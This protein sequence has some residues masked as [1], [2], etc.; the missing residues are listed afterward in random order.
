VDCFDSSRLPGESAAFRLLSRWLVSIRFRSPW[1]IGSSPWLSGWIASTCLDSPGE[2]DLTVTSS[3]DCFDSS[4][5]PGELAAFRLLSRWVVSTRFRSPMDR[6]G[7]PRL[8]GWIASTC[9]DSPSELATLRLP[10]RWIA[11]A[12][13]DSPVSPPPFGCFLGGLSRFASALRWIV[14]ACLGSPGGLLRLAS[15]LCELAT[16]RLPSRWIASAHLDFPVS[17]LPFGC[18]LGGLSRFASALRWIASAHLDSP[19]S[20]LPFGRLLGGLSRLASALRRSSWLASALRVDCQCSPRLSG[21]SAAFRPPSRWIASAHLD[22]PVS[23][24]P[25][26][27]LLGGLS[28]FASA[29]RGSSWLALA[30]R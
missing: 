19:V 10:P 12:H 27:R 14:T 2:L 6:H 16:L 21:E 15:T 13:L 26:G 9:L 17:P 30:L 22:S 5:L 25:F 23:R 24:L 8:S 3:V 28:R 18:L 11:S 1:I 29:L 7:V 20:R 4:R